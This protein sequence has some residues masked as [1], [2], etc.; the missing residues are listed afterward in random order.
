VKDTKEASKAKRKKFYR[1]IHFMD[2]LHSFWECVV[3]GGVGQ[4]DPPI[5]GKIDFIRSELPN[6]D[7]DIICFDISKDGCTPFYRK[8][9]EE[10]DEG[11][12]RMRGA[13]V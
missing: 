2:P 7:W 5:N 6:R 3:T 13:L 9:N 12:V 8:G 11:Y 1:I 4:I 10:W